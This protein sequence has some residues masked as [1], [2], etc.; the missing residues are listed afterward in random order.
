[1]VNLILCGGSGTRLW[2]LSR[3]K[4]PKQYSKIFGGKSLFQENILRNSSLCDRVL[5]ATNV[6]HLPL[7]KEQLGQDQLDGLD[8]GQV[9]GLLEPVGRN[10]A[11]AIALAL[12]KLADEGDPIVLVTPSDHRITNL[13]EYR[14]AVVRAEELARQGYLVTFGIKPKYAE[15]GYGYIET[16]GEDVRSFKE[17]PDKPTAQAYVA[18][19]RYYWNSGMFVFRSSTFLSELAEHSPQVYDAAR[20]AYKGAGKGAFLEPSWQDMEA[21]PSISIDYAVME[22]SKR[23]KVVTCDPGWS[24]LGSFDALYDETPKV[25]ATGAAGESPRSESPRSDIS[26]SDSSEGNAIMAPDVTLL[27]TKRCLV[28]GKDKPIILAGVEDLIV[29]Q[30]EDATLI[31]R[32]GQSQNVR[33]VLRV[34]ERS[35]P[36]LL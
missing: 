36:G 20:R 3:Q 35:N 12:L 30:T 2:P 27:D 21:I 17:K 6:E 25:S 4:A 34:I 7:I 10:T 32:R 15:T 16:D 5:V 9:E 19:G 22:K 26:R 28:V 33:D 1:M 14:R 11:P 8:V 18:S 31:M 29:V 13:P 24:D 23:V